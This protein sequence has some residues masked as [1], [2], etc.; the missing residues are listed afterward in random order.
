MNRK[1]VVKIL[2]TVLVATGAGVLIFQMTLGKLTAEE[3]IQQAREYCGGEGVCG[4][5]LTDAVHKETGAAYSSTCLAPG[6]EAR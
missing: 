1:A 6:W 5:A 4:Q 3:A 2:V